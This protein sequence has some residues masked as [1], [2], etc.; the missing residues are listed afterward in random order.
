MI[1][2][3][4]D[5]YVSSQLNG[6]RL[7][8]ADE[9]K[10]AVELDQ[11][12][13]A[14]IESIQISK[15]F[16]PEQQGDASGGAV[17][18]WLR[19][20]PEETTFQ[21]KGQYTYNSQVGN[22]T[23]FL[24]YDGGGVSF[25]GMDGGGRDIQY[26][27]LGGN[28][29]GAAGTSTGDAPTDYKWSLSGGGKHELDNGVKLGGFASLFYKRDSSFYDD[30]V[31]DSYWVRNPGAEM[32]PQAVQGVPEDGDFKTALFD[33]IRARQSVQ[34][35]GLA[36]LGVETEDNSV[37]LTYLYSHTADD[38][39]TLA[40]DTRGK[41][42]YFPGYDPDNPTG[43]GNTPDARNSAPYIRTETLEYTERTTGSL[44]LSGRHSLP[45]GEFTIGD[46]FKFYQ[47]EVQWIASRSSAD[48]NQPDKRQFGALWMPASF[49]PGVPPFVPPFT[50]A[51]I[52]L[53]FKP[54][55]SFDL[56][57]FQ[58]IWK[59][60]EEDSEQYSVNMRLPFEQWSG[61]KGSVNVG[62]FDDSVTRKFDQETFSNFG[63]GAASYNGEFDEPWSAVFPY[64][65]HPITGSNADVDYHGSQDIFAS[66]AMVD[67]PLASSL[68]L[69]GGARFEST[70]IGI[71]NRPESLALW[72]PPGATAPVD[73]NSDEADVD[74][75]QRDV[76]PA[77][78]LQ[79]EPLDH[80]TLRASYSQTVA[81]QTFKELTP[82]LQ[83]EFL[84]GPIF[85]GNPDLQM[86]ALQNY[87]VRVD[88]TPYE[89]GLLSA[90]WFKKDIENPIENVQRIASLTYTTPVNYPKGELTGIELEVRQ[91]LGHF[92]ETMAGL[93][94]GANATFIESHV[95]L[96]A[97]DSADFDAPNIQAPMTEREMT[98][99]PDH[100][101][102]LYLTYD[103]PNSG[104]QI[105]LF[106][107][108]QG[109]ML[110]AGAATSNGN[111]VPSIYAKEY[112]TLNMSL[113]QKLGDHFRLQLQAKNLT[114]PDI[115]EVYRS[116][117]IADDVTRSSL[118]RGIEY[119][120][121]LS[122]NF[123]F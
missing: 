76:L 21:F 85:I 78:G 16:T 42:Y 106:Y 104:T 17:N 120:I 51:P 45:I 117:Y 13:A 70:R 98:N 119:S 32:T 35:G 88:C 74:F 101:Y 91:D 25:L 43:T 14:V 40:E 29:D 80:V 103:V 11:F 110:V 83:Q 84:G 56:G 26:D 60:I 28:W 67:L 49:N 53:P 2:G 72:F 12:P 86:S 3:L 66:Y 82:I 105:G 114:N 5:R 116:E 77:I 55:A 19:G 24:T 4:P 50:T 37:G 18:V 121:S 57:N 30:G 20:I 69:T 34:W 62:V 90:S 79:Y 109:D 87:D 92:W 108:V 58:R 31:F 64:E 68:S 100:L 111:F 61:D 115:E 97:Q 112:G 41:A 52:W 46:T 48:L 118:S 96:P 39:A 15:T 10:R 59:T 94:L 81:R 23:D 1:R 22:R 33:V 36:T 9:N 65:D 71:E 63:D 99:A 27:N 89:G 75:E 122:A 47:P 102:N 93:S 123:A 107:T 73:L 38:V 8:T 44:Q 95:T 54:A 7:P 6:V 113:S